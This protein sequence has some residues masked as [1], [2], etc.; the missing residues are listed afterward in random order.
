MKSAAN[1]PT[2]PSERDH[3]LAG[4]PQEPSDDIS[5]DDA[6]SPGE[7][8]VIF[9]AIPPDDDAAPLHAF[10]PRPQATHETGRPAAP[11][12]APEDPLAAFRAAAAAAEATIAS[13]TG[14]TPAAPR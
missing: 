11:P 14:G 13:L 1:K 3:R 6:E 10:T 12:P 4:A 5:S 7:Q 2:H 8:T 9:S